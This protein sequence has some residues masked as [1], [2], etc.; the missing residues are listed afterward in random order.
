MLNKQWQYFIL[1]H[2]REEDQAW[3]RNIH[4]L[5]DKHIWYFG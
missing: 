1:I 3:K 4:I 5:S 2:I